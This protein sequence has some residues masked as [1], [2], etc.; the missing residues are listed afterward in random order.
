MKHFFLFLFSISGVLFHSCNFNQGSSLPEVKLIP[1][2][3]GAK[4]GYIDFKGAIIINPQFNYA[5]PFYEGLAEFT[6]PEGK[7]GFVNEEGQYI[8][9][10]IY[11]HASRFSEGL[12]PVVGENEAPKYIDA[13]GEV[14]FSVANAEY[15]SIFHEGLA[16]VRINDKWGY[17]DK[18]G[19]IKIN[20]QFD[21]AGPFKDGLARFTKKVNENEYLQ[22]YINQK[23]DII[24]QPIFKDANEFFDGLARV[25]DGKNYGFISKE[26]KYI[27]NPQFAYA[28]D[29][30][31][32]RAAFKQGN[33]WGYIDKNGKYIVNPMF[34]NAGQAYNSTLFLVQNTDG[35]YGYVD[36]EGRYVINAQFEQA[37]PFLGT[38]A[39][40]YSGEKWGIVDAKGK[41]AVNPQ[42]DDVNIGGVFNYSNNSVE[43]EYFDVAVISSKVLENASLNSFYSLSAKS[44]LNDV[45]AAHPEVNSRLAAYRSAVSI[46]PRTVLNKYCSLNYVQFGFRDQVKENIPQYQSVQRYDPYK[47]GYYTAQNFVGYSYQLNYS[48]PLTFIDYSIDLIGKGSGKALSATKGIVEGMKTQMNL[49]LDQEGYEDRVN[50]EERGVFLL[51]NTFLSSLVNYDKDNIHIHTQFKSESQEA[52]MDTT[53]QM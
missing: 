19:Q 6:S 48:T 21:D 4:W 26:G 14:K 31:N 23:G 40:F 1:Y 9:N 52:M 43:S 25:S 49:N 24:I 29:F 50:T 13:K 30:H 47:G 53:K 11:V 42:F 33:S 3:A 8:I 2:K 38:Y 41:Y 51:S 20:P 44:T 45:I 15:A 16:A 39:F 12:A 28:S 18:T 5:E 32:G 27:I 22:G 17:I 10:P 36:D 46:Y 7:V 34:S 35:K 37:T